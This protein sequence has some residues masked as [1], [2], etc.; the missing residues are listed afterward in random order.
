MAQLHAKAAS[1]MPAQSHLQLLTVLQVQYAAAAGLYD[2]A[3][4][5]ISWFTVLLQGNS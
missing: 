5:E 2:S 4:V 3:F 1:H